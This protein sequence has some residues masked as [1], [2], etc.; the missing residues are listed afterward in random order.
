MARSAPALGAEVPQPP[1]GLQQLLDIYPDARI[2]YTHRDPQKTVPSL[3]SL[4]AVTWCM[5]SD[6]VDL[7]QRRRTSRSIWRERCEAAGRA[8]MQIIP[9][10]QIVHVEY[11]DLVADPV[12]MA[13]SVYERFGY[14]TD[15]ALKARMRSWLAEHPSDKHGKHATRWSDFGLTEEEVRQ[16]LM[17]GVELRRANA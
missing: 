4:A 6:T 3:C 1:L 14:P 5:T 7:R 2:V 8:A 10:D 9:R 17:S 16:R 12:A 11:D 13:M 15:P